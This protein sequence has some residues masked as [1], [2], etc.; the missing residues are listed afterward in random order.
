VFWYSLDCLLARLETKLYYFRPSE[1][2][3]PKR[4]LQIIDLGSGLSFS[5]GDHF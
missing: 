5:L 1:L 2:L 4:K 3:S